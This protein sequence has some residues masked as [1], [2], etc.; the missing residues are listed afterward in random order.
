VWWKGGIAGLWVNN[1]WVRLAGWVLAVAV[2]TFAV[3]AVA[4]QWHTLVT[5]KVAWHVRPLYLAGAVALIL[6]NYAVLVQAW[7]IMLRGWRQELPFMDSVRIWIVSSLGKYV[8]G[9][10]WAVAGMALMAQRSGVAAWA[11]TASAV[12]LQSLAVGAGAAVTGIA[13]SA[14]LEAQAP[15]VRMALVGLIVASA[16]GL[17]ALLWPPVTRRLLRLARVAAPPEQSPGVGAIAAGLVANVFAWLSYGLSLW[18]LANGL[19]DVPGLPLRL[20]ISAFAASYVSGLLALFAPG[21]IGVREAV[22]FLMLDGVVGPGIAAALAV[23]S[24]LLLT[25]TE[26]GAAVPFLVLQRG[27][28]RAAD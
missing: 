10:V 20:A 9:K 15:W 25:V 1:R 7:R 12:V 24:R 22:F 18:L 8:P 14:R 5:Q 26:I 2:A 27:E 3:R 19:F 4:G 17:A 16:V 6:A 13:G 23:A 28:R 11:A 21:G